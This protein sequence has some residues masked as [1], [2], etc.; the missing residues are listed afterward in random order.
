VNP[1]SV[2]PVKKSW[3]SLKDGIEGQVLDYSYEKGSMKITLPDEQTISVSVSTNVM[4]DH[5]SDGQVLIQKVDVLK[6]NLG[7]EIL[8]K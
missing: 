3:Q 5:S 7:F 1:E 8:L 4:K 6:Q 2:D